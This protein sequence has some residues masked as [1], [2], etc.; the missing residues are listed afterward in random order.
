MTDANAVVFD[1]A[2]QFTGCIPGIMEVLRRQGLVSSSRCLNPKEA[3]SPGQGEELDRIARE[4]P[5]LT[6]DAFVKEN[7]DRWLS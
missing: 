7:L 6:D 2:N 5:F 3:L 4:Y 1:V